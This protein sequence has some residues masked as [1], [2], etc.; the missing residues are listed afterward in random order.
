MRLKKKSESDKAIEKVLLDA[1]ARSRK[2]VRIVRTDG[3]GIFG[4][5][6]SFQELKEKEKFYMRDPL[7]MTTDKTRE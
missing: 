3:D 7:P 5:S 4:R 1:K 2:E 6:K